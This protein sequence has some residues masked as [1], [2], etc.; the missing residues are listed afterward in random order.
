MTATSSIFWVSTDMETLSYLQRRGQIEHYF[1]RTAAETWKRLTSDAPV[2]GIRATVRA[3]REEMRATLLSWL[4][5]DLSGR[6][7]LDAGCGTGV[8]SQEA[9]RRGARVV[10]IDLSPTLV[11]HAREAGGGEPGQGS[12]DY[13][14]GDMLDEGLGEFDHAV[15]MDSLIHYGAPDVVRSLGRL[16]GRT[17]HSMVF[18]FAPQ[19]P[20][21]RVMHAVGRWFPRADRAPAIEPVAEGV[22]R[23][24]IAR[25]PQ[26]AG[27]RV[28]RTQR[29]TSGFYK[30]QAVELLR[31]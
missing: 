24:L 28:G 31:A 4:P 10:A 11:A 6:R 27:W 14:V 20:A 30:S 12:I 7:L 18:T 17:R 19:T 22:L 15:A 8:L 1:D 5:A 21:L 3:G 2:S 9:A 25:H 16:A 23:D 13:R 26:L 29:V